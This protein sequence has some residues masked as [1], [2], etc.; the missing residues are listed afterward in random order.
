MS[1]PV[2]VWISAA[3]YPVYRCGGWAFVRN[4]RGAVS[5]MAGGERHSTGM[6]V[7]LAGLAAGLQGLPA[8]TDVVEIQT[9]SP[10]LA[11]LAT[12]LSAPQAPGAKPPGDDGAD[13][14]LWA[15][16]LTAAK[17]RRLS[18][19]GVPPQPKTPAP[20]PAPGP[21]S[22]GTRPRRPGPSPPPFPSRTWRRFRDWVRGWLG[23]RRFPQRQ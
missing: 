9:T 23:R 15:Q 2:R 6:R 12:F 7:A 22:P 1:T 17:G 8:T 11:A 16:I 20:S 5:G 19:V 4:V 18:V 3:F 14:D 13:L 10:E 21:I